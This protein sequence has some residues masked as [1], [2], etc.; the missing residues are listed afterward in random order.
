MDEEARLLL[1]LSDGQER[2]FSAGEV[3][4]KKDFLARLRQEEEREPT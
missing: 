1:R 2:A 3:Q 4:I